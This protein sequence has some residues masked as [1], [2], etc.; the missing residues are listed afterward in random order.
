MLN[1]IHR[2]ARADAVGVVSEFNSQSGKFHLL[3][4]PAVPRELVPVEGLGV[5]DGIVGA[6]ENT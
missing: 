2:L 5:A 1:T 4:L 6:C 3:Q